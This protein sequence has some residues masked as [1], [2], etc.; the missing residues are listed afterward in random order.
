[1]VKVRP[2]GEYN[3]GVVQTD[4]FPYENQGHDGTWFVLMSDCFVR[5]YSVA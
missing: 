2:D 1:M 5:F 4:E 3:F